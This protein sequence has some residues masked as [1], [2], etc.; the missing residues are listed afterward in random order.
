MVRKLIDPNIEVN[1]TLS[2]S[3]KNF[4]VFIIKWLE[5]AII[6]C[7][8]TYLKCFKNIVKGPIW[9]LGN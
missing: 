7:L 3:N 5:Y 2:I 1:I 9:E 6:H 4:R 8:E